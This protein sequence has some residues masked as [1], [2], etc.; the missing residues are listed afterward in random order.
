MKNKWH[1]LASGQH[2]PWCVWNVE[3][4]LFLQLEVVL[5]GYHSTA[6]LPQYNAGIPQ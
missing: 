3:S 5:L 6:G 4:K 1:L 2:I